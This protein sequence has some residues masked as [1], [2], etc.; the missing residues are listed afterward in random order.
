MTLRAVEVL[1]TADV[2]VAEDTRQA[3]RLLAHLGAHTPTRSF[4]EHNGAR[5]LPGLL[6]RLAA[7]RR[8]R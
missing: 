4:N 1:R 6:T 3:A 8:W 5:R 7:G 2:V